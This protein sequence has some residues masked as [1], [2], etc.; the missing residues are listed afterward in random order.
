MEF[1]R[2]CPLLLLVKGVFREE[3][4]R[5]KSYENSTVLGYNM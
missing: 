2:Q 3:K 4:W 1:P 5:R